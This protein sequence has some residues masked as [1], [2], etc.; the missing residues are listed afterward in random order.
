MDQDEFP[1]AFKFLKE[2]GVESST[3]GEI[4]AEIHASQQLQSSILDTLEE[5]SDANLIATLEG[6]LK[7]ISLTDQPSQTPRPPIGSVSTTDQAAGGSK[8][9]INSW[10]DD[11]ATRYYKLEAQHEEKRNAAREQNR[12]A[13]EQKETQR[14]ERKDNRAAASEKRRQGLKDL[15][16]SVKSGAKSGYGRV[17]GSK[18]QINSSMSE[19]SGTPMTEPG[20]LFKGLTPLGNGQ[21]KVNNANT[22]GWIL[23]CVVVMWLLYKA[24]FEAFHVITFGFA[25]SMVIPLLLNELLDGQGGGGLLLALSSVAWLS[26][27]VPP[28]IGMPFDG[29]ENQTLVLFIGGPTSI[30][31]PLLLSACT[32]LAAMDGSDALL[33]TKRFGQ[34][35]WSWPLVASAIA[36]M[37]GFFNLGLNFPS[38]FWLMTLTNLFSVGAVLCI[39]RGRTNFWIYGI[40]LA[41]II[42]PMSTLPFS[43]LSGH[44]LALAVLPLAVWVITFLAADLIHTPRGPR[45]IVIALFCQI[46]S[47]ARFSDTIPQVAIQSLLPGLLLLI[48]AELN[49]RH[50]NP[51]IHQVIRVLVPDSKNQSHRLKFERVVAVVGAS[52]SGKSCFL[53]SLWTLLTD[54]VSRDLWYG[55]A[56]Y[57]T[58]ASRSPPFLMSDVISLLN[59]PG[60]IGTHNDDDKVSLLRELLSHR[61]MNASMTQEIRQGILP[62]SDSVFPFSVTSPPKVRRFLDQY[63][64]C[65]AEPDRE[66]RKV[67]NPTVDVTKDLAIQ[68]EFTAEVQ[69]TQSVYFGLKADESISERPVRYSI[70]TLDMKGEHFRDAV[71]TLAGRDIKSKSIG[72]LLAVMRKNP[73][74]YDTATQ[75]VTRLITQASDILLIL[76]SN[77]FTGQDRKS[78]NEALSFMRLV[79][80]LAAVPGVKTNHIS[81]LLNK[82]DL[83]ITRGDERSRLMKGGALDDWSQ[84]LDRD[85]ALKSLDENTNHFSQ[86]AQ[87][88]SIDAYYSCTLGGLITADNGTGNGTKRIFPPRPM[89]PVNVFEPLLRCFL[90]RDSGEEETA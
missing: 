69:S 17:G 22:A 78:A 38:G 36:L 16:G 27:L 19:K 39:L 51:A 60:G 84:M 79:D 10:D 2:L 33:N 90:P 76:D 7:L 70:R 75:V 77:D 12:V 24:G 25:L 42:S 57:L 46:V 50:Q 83:L 68:L 11:A 29:P 35:P 73:A 81:C 44:F 71:D 8:S 80:D 4:R 48:V 54:P 74:K 67:L 32:F 15:A 87:N 45:F 85:H 66:K 34:S 55:N 21:R 62:Q 52:S 37:C 72:E 88:V 49:H 86:H 23:T 6:E 59:I 13:R 58:D 41:T 14:Q 31:L 40:I 9:Q 63:S 3:V 65:L 26:L 28:L 5:T 56:P 20:V 89:I 47:F 43:D 82:A 64:N 61:G 1:F 53:G 18:S 30:V